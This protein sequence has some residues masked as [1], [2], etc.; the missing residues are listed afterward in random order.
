[1]IS[2]RINSLED[3]NKLYNICNKYKEDIDVIYQRQIIDGKSYL[4]I[5]SLMGHIVTLE[6][7]TEDKNIKDQFNKEF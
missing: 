4:G 1:M 3:A 2:Y 7:I 6:I 5:V